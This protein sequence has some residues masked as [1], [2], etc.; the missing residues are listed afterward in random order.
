MS[1]VTKD[2]KKDMKKKEKK[3]NDNIQ[4]VSY[5]AH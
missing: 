4:N 5:A 2:A 1:I 3:N